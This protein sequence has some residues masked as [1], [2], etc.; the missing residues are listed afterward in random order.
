LLQAG[1][2]P[3]AS[4]LLNEFNNQAGDNAITA[5]PVGQFT[6]EDPTGAGSLR[7]ARLLCLAAGSEG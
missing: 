2:V 6:R 5:N 4:D 3:I 1:I 7:P